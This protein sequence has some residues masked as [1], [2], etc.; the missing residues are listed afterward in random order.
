MAEQPPT[1]RK[2]DRYKAS[3]YRT[4]NFKMPERYDS[5][6]WMTSCQIPLLDRA[7]IEELASRIGSLAILDVGCATGRLLGK[8]ASAG[9]TRL[10][11][12]DL[13][14]N[15]L[16]V[17][18][19]RM[20]RQGAHAEL[21]VADA[22]ESLPWPAESFDVVTVT[23]VLHHFYR[24]HDALQEIYRVL[25]PEGRVLVVDPCFFP[26]LRQL[27][28]LC[29][30]VAPHEGDCRFYSRRRA[31]EILGNVSFCCS[32]SKRIGCWGYLISAV[33]RGSPKGAA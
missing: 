20:A 18:R 12:V 25:R 13:A 11:G 22:E 29:L 23:G 26:L 10:S 31:A 9:A 8:L 17:A 32:P 30:R 4:Y 2:H 5:S 6:I 33:K 7:I 15:I 14:P 21:K 16:E 19:E 1:F 3:S 24:P 28:N 27:M